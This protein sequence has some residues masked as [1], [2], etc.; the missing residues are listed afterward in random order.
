LREN[1]LYIETGQVA[2]S[3][4]VINTIIENKKYNIYVE[5]MRNRFPIATAQ[6]LTEYVRALR[7]S[8]GQTQADVA[9][10]L[11]VSTARVAI[12]EKDVGR[13]STSSLLALLSVLSAHLELHTDGAVT[14]AE[15]PRDEVAS[16]TDRP[17]TAPTTR[18]ASRGGEW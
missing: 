6:Q 11:G 1:N 5:C 7:K 15:G 13:L 14:P 9:R 12:I 3:T 18:R 2:D 16:S 10:I 8:R 17:T 4:P